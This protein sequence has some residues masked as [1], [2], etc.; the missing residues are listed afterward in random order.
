MWRSFGILDLM[1][2]KY[3]NIGGCLLLLNSWHTILA[4][5]VVFAL[6]KSSA[7]HCSP[8]YMDSALLACLHIR[9]FWLVLGW[10]TSTLSLFF[11]FLSKY[12]AVSSVMHPTGIDIDTLLWIILL[13]K[14]SARKVIRLKHELW[15]FGSCG[16]ANAVWSYSKLASECPRLLFFWP[17]VWGFHAYGAGLLCSPKSEISWAHT[18]RDYTCYKWQLYNPL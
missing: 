11:F 15:K 1:R 2:P 9:L 16:Y 13:N 6:S 12:L 7:T 14:A 10:T 18:T 3:V 17:G 5:I 8:S 4:G